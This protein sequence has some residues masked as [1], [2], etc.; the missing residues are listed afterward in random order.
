MD[1]PR[2]DIQFRKYPRI[3]IQIDSLHRLVGF[4]TQPFTL[5]LDEF[6]SILDQLSSGL[7]QQGLMEH[8]MDRLVT[9]MQTCDGVLVMDAFIKHQGIKL[10]KSLV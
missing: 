4:Q 10:I 2:G 7:N 9:L 8:S 3:A 1:L 5:I 6:E